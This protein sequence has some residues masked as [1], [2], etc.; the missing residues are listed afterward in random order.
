MYGIR[1]EIYEKII[2]ISKKYNNYAFLLFG[3]RARGDYK[4]NSDIDIAICGNVSKEDEAGIKNEF[5]MIDMEYMVDLIFLKNVKNDELLKN[6]KNEGV[7]LK[8]KG[9]KKEKW[10]YIRR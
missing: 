6:I 5:D 4:K 3:S 9:L 10:I 7:E 8:W 1:E 2:N